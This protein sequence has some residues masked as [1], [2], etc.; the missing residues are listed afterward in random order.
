MS[1]TLE[2]FQSTFAELM[3]APQQRLTS[4]TPEQ[5]AFFGETG[6]KLSARL[7]IYRN[8]IFITLGQTLREN[9]PLLEKLVGEAFMKRLSHDYILAHPPTQGCLNGYGAELPQFLHHFLETHDQASMAYLPDLA[10][11]EF[12]HC[13]AYFAADDQPLTLSMLQQIAPEALAEQ[14]FC[15]RDSVTLLC[16]SYPLVALHEF[17]ET[18]KNPP[19]LEGEQPLYLLVHRP[20]LQTAVVELSASLFHLLRG[21]KA[22]PL[23]AALEATLGFDPEFDFNSAL[24]QLIQLQVLQTPQSTENPLTA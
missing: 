20:Q 19:E 21:L 14:R 11:Y 15:L 5:Q 2:E 13:K 1:A 3:L 22:Q 12:A 8:N 16:S 23:G 18:Q 4:L 7:A 6:Q 10:H 9:F 17:I 24:P